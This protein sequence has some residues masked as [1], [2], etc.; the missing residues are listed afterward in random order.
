[1]PLSPRTGFEEG[2]GVLIDGTAQLLS[3]GGD[4]SD[5]ADRYYRQTLRG[6]AAAFG[7]PPG[8]GEGAL[9]LQLQKLTE[10]AGIRFDLAHCESALQGLGGDDR[11]ARIRAVALAR[12]LYQ[13]RLEMMHGNRE[14]R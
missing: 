12:R 7:L 6:V 4:V 9:R 11:R 5:S 1:K 2:K 14:S 10:R 13:W 3:S 8:L